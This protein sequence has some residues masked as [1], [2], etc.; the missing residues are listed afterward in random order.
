MAISGSGHPLVHSDLV[1]RETRV[2]DITDQ[3][4]STWDKI[5]E[6]LERRRQADALALAEFAVEHECRFV[7]DI[8]TGWA[9]EIRR[10][11]AGRGIPE[12]GLLRVDERLRSVLAYPDGEPYSP[13]L[14]WQRLQEAKD[15]LRGRIE[16]SEW[17]EAELA[18]P[19]ACEAWRVVHDRVVDASFGWM[20]AFVEYFGETAV[21]EMYD[22]IG[23]EHFD[24]FFA[25]ADP[26]RRA[27]DDEG[28]AA[29]LLDTA[30][31]M[32]VHLSTVRRDG[33]PI[34]LI[35]HEDRWEMTF[36]PCGSGGRALRG[37]I[38]EGTP[39]RLE[40]PY[41]FAYIEGAYDWTD[42]K[43]G[44]CVYCNHCQLLYEQWPMDRAGIPFLVVDPPTYPEGVGHDDPQK[45]RYTIYK[46]AEAVPDEVYTRCGKKRPG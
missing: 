6:A 1:G 33:A 17:D 31:A 38:V 29:V 36:D 8:L 19:P 24:E 27:W 2:G 28:R 18:V 23:G 14:G 21:P 12:D 20:S 7:Y 40:P 42:G 5:R 35:E 26:K 30:E 43:S 3:C 10:L 13:E 15:T 11:L 44:M 46:S 16:A 4:R 25:L 39:S 41:E 37:D 34:E 32:R 45:C 9:I 22:E